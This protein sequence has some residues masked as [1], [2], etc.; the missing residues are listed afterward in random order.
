MDG[1]RNPS[2]DV[3]VE[4]EMKEREEVR[5]DRRPGVVGDRGLDRVSSEPSC[6]DRSDPSVVV[7]LQEDLRSASMVGECGCSMAC[8]SVDER[9]IPCCLASGIDIVA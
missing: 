6:V 2:G 1:R 3:N 7:P 9:E 5:L 4:V 8:D